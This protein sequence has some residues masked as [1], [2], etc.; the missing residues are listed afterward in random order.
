VRDGVR[1]GYQVIEPYLKQGQKIAEQ[2]VATPYAAD[3]GNGHSEQPDFG[4]VQL[5]TELMANWSDM[6]GTFTEAL[7]SATGSIRPPERWRASPSSAAASK[8]SAPS[9]VQLA[10]ELTSRRPAL[11]DVEFFPGRETLDLAAHALR[12]LDSSAAEIAVVCERQ[13]DR[14]RT[15]VS[16]RVSDDQPSGL[17][18][19]ALMN[20]RD[21]S[22][23]GIVSL[24]IR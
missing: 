17:Y 3:R 9:A 24:R 7:S 12:C 8:A 13:P 20:S 10:Y 22:P 5:L 18:T 23:V 2:F 15:I 21:G 4:S 19:G 14:Q 6:V 11:V 1:L 16:I